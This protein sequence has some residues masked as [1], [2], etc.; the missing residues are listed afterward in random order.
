MKNKNS[1]P[2]L[3]SKSK[4]VS[5]MNLFES[6]INEPIELIN[7]DTNQIQTSNDNLYQVDFSN[8]SVYLIHWTKYVIKDSEPD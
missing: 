8:N 2:T 7:V 1:F 3:K 4:V 5:L 6:K